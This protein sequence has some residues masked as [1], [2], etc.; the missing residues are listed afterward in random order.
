[1]LD[2]S[3][4]LLPIDLEEP[5]LTAVHQAAAL[6]RRFHSQLLVV[7]VISRLSYLGLHSHSHGDQLPAEIKAAEDRLDSAILPELA[8]LSVRREVF[9][10]NPTRLIPKIAQ[11]E[12]QGLIVMGSHGWGALTATLIG[13]VSGAVLQGTHVPVWTAPPGL[14]AGAEVQVRTILCGVD[15]TDSDGHIVQNAAA[16]AKTFGAKLVLAHVTPSVERYGPGGTYELTDFK[17][18][19]VD[20]SM[21]QLTKVREALGMEADFFV[22]S[23]STSKVLAEAATHTSS[24]LLVIGRPTSINSLGDDNYAIIRDSPIAVLTV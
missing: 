12:K 15:F 19:L 18:A 2:F 9:Q 13:S 7:H 8:G 1:M 14:Q 16:L 6:A 24:D 20:S 3:R 5:S 11:D 4:I 17:K 22:G 21:R 10:G 23:G